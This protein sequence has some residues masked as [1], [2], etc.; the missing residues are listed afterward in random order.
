MQS[1]SPEKLI[2]IYKKEIEQARKE[3]NYEL[4]FIRTD[5]IEKLENLLCVTAH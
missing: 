2:E 1:Y 3:K 4:I 5:Q